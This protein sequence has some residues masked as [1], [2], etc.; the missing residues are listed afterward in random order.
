MRRFL[1]LVL[2]LA[3]LLPITA[4]AQATADQLNRVSLEALTARPAGG[5]GGGYG[6]APHR[7]SSYRYHGRRS[8]AHRGYRHY[9]AGSSYRGR[10]HHSRY[11][12]HRRPYRTA[13]YR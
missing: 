7:A 10:V 1:L 4:R 8:Y 5:G 2:L 13:R 6:R 3:S 12:Y 9:A 11:A